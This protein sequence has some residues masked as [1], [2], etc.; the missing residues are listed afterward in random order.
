MVRFSYSD[1]LERIPEPPKWWFQ[2]IPRYSEFS[3]DLVRY[4]S[5]EVALIE[6]QCQQCHY[7]FDVAVSGPGG[8]WSFHDWVEVYG[9]FGIGD[10]PNVGCCGTGLHHHVNELRVKE[11]WVRHGAFDDW[12]RDPAMEISLSEAPENVAAPQSIDE[13]LAV[14]GLDGQWWSATKHGDFAKIYRL[15][16]KVGIT[17]IR[18]KEI[19]SNWLVISDHIRKWQSVDLQVC[20]GHRVLVSLEEPWFQC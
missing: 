20:P 10:P 6:T 11:F 18:A 13:K 16:R 15:L 12:V 5:G 14:L 17:R 19:V 4:S 2:G 9:K 7:P 3:P 8:H 1:I